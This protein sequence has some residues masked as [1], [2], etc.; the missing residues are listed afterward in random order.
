MNH[1]L[2]PTL[3]DEE[4]TAVDFLSIKTGI[5]K[6]KIKTAMTRG[7]VW[8]H[9]KGQQRRLR[10]AKQQ[11]TSGMQVSMYYSEAVLSY[12]PPLPD[13]IADKSDF[14]VW[15]KPVGVMSGGSRFGDHCAINRIIEK[16]LDRP[17]FLVHRLDRFVSGVMVLAHTK[18]TAAALSKEF[19]ERR[20]RKVYEATVTGAVQEPIAISTDIDGKSAHSMVTPVECLENHTRVS[21]EIT[22][23]RK[24]QIRRHLASVGHP[25]VGD[26]LYGTADQEGIQ[27]RSVLLEFT[28]PITGERKTYKSS[29]LET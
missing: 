23:G 21:V 16:Q 28:S 9:D 22:T 5:S 12:E 10:R 17:T 25:I 14:S 8:L 24:H 18:K 20:I 15:Y 19:Q 13:L 2:P 11:L 1:E 7:A 26:R 4:T 3:I 27:L 6:Q 29:L